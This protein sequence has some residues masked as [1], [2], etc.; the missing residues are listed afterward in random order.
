MRR[1]E[2]KR[3]VILGLLVA[4]LLIVAFG[5]G[6]HYLEHRGDGRGST[7]IGAHKLKF[8]EDLDKRYY[9]DHNIE[10]YLLIGTDD[11]GQQSKDGQQT[12]GGMA[13]FLLLFVMGRF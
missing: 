2:S 9:I 10:T 11:S 3:R 12:H 6:L 1:R 4:V 8:F 5:A 13:D 7:D